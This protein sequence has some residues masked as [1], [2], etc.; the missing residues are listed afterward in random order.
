V[1][2]QSKIGCAA[3]AILASTLGFASL[4]HAAPFAGVA[5]TVIA[6]ERTQMAAETD[7]LIQK[8][9]HKGKMEVHHHHHH[10]HYHEHPAQ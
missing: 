2:L 10:H 6:V 4:T 5:D 7:G 1:S 8:A 9:H 3:A